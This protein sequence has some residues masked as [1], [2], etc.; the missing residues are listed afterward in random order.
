M[1]WRT[2]AKERTEYLKFILTKNQ[3]LGEPT[4]TEEEFEEM[5]IQWEVSDQLIK[6]KRMQR[7]RDEKRKQGIL[8]T[9]LIT[10]C[11][12]QKVQL[13][14]VVEYQNELISKI[15]KAKYNYL[16]EAKARFEYYGSEGYNPHIHIVTNKVK[17]DG[18]VAQSIRRKCEMVFTGNNP[19]YRVNVVSGKDDRHLKYIDGDKSNQDE[20]MK[21]D[22]EVR[23]KFKISETILI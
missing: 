17:T 12:D 20:L 6:E 9:Q 3:G 22:N 13:E 21:K 8:S 16:D 7:V 14:Q 15:Q 11:F 10:I 5:M 2:T 23:E 4:M 18:A 1:E 19:V